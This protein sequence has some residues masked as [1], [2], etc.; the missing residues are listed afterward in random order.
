MRLSPS[1][2]YILG[3][4]LIT[5]LNSH[6]SQDAV[7]HG[8]N[9]ISSCP[10][11]LWAHF[12]SPPEEE[13][14]I[15]ASGARCSMEAKLGP[16][17]YLICIAFN[18]MTELWSARCAVQ[19]SSQDLLERMQLDDQAKVP[20][21]HRIRWHGDAEHSMAGWRKSRNSIPQEVVAIRKTYIEVV[22]ID[23]PALGLTEPHP[24][25]RKARSGRPKMLSNWT[26]PYAKD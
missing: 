14:T 19:V 20:R 8:A 1:G 15:R 3:W 23:C 18:A 10:P 21:T 9:S 13:V 4:W 2:L 6:L 5:R 11:S 7:S 22:G 24:S 17:P 26:H 16:Q 25:D 12:L